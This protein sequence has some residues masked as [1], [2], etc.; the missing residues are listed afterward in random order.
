MEWADYGV[1]KVEYDHK[2]HRIV[3]ALCVPKPYYNSDGERVTLTRDEMVEAMEKGKTFVSVHKCR[4]RW[5][6][7]LSLFPMEVNG[8]TYIRMRH[9]M[10]PMDSHERI[11]E[12]CPQY[13]E[14]SL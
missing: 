6:K 12:W 9:S 7:G 3:R 13:H 10:V 5:T 1:V 8:E 14:I 2:T 4:N 11:P